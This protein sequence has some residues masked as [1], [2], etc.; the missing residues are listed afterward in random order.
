MIRFATFADAATV[1]AIYAHYVHKTCITFVNEAPTPADFVSRISDPRFPFL[2]AEVND[3]VVGFIYA[4]TFRTKAAYRWDV[5]LSIYLAPGMEG[6]GLGSELMAQCLEILT[7]QGYLNVY[8]CITLPGERSVALHGKF[9]FRELGRFPRSGYK[10]GQWHDVIWM[11]RTL[12]TAE[13]TP[14]EPRLLT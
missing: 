7:R 4:S 13:G 14:D 8:S 3:R 2:V 1:A 9:G 11:G 12:A 6:Q 5:E 10:M